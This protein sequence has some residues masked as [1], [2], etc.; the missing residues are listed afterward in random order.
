MTAFRTGHRKTDVPLVVNVE[1][2]R[3]TPPVRIFGAQSSFGGLVTLL[4]IPGHPDAAFQLVTV[5]AEGTLGLDG[6]QI[7]ISDNLLTG[8]YTIVVDATAPGF[9]GSQQM[10]FQIEVEGDI[11][12]LD[13]D[14]ALGASQLGMTVYRRCGVRGG[15][16]GDFIRRGRG[17]YFSGAAQGRD[18]Y[19]VIH[20]ALEYRLCQERGRHN[21]WL[22]S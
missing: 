22:L 11:V 13:L 18:A 20:P 19:N 1:S 16:I 5:S 7:T 12:D 17:W 8:E 21:G 3:S 2:L 15:D 6:A 9:L 4:S 14:R 10:E